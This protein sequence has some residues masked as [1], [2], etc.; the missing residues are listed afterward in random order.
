M[1]NDTKAGP[2]KG[3]AQPAR[4]DVVDEE[5]LS[6]VS[7]PLMDD[8]LAIV[9]DGRSN[10]GVFSRAATGI[11]T[12]LLWEACRDLQTDA[13]TVPGFS[14]DAITVSRVRRPP[15]GLSILRAGETFVMPFRMLFPNAPLLHLGVIRDEA[16]LDHHVYTDNL[17]KLPV[18]TGTLLILDPMLATGGSIAVAIE[19]ARRRFTGEIIV[20]SLVSA[21]LGVQVV[22]SADKHARIV[23]AALDHGLNE[24]GF[25]VPGL[26]DA[27]D[28]FF[29]TS[30][31]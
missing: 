23:T 31:R 17:E 25:I 19:R 14:G 11:A 12:F 2:L 21:P 6:I 22:L 8:L 10:P 29:G 28:R 27:G 20:V 24:Q 3:R 15:S 30:N 7:H 9:R 16:T 18:D 5:R 26:G 4:A 1:T 13:D